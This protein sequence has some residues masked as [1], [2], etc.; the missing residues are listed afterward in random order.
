MRISRSGSIWLRSI[1]HYLVFPILCLFSSARIIILHVPNISHSSLGCVMWPICPPFAF[2]F[3]KL[4][5]HYDTCLYLRLLTSVHALLIFLRSFAL[6][7]LISTQN[8]S[9]ELWN[10][11]RVWMLW[12]Q[13]IML[14]KKAALSSWK[15]RRIFIGAVI[16]RLR[17]QSHTQHTQTRARKQTSNGR[18]SSI[19]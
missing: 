18:A 9:I 7:R 4:R 12:R 13:M 6:V 15:Y 3:C 8:R 5:I 1:W 2:Y 11:Q 14:K 16:C 10:N 19:K 17:K